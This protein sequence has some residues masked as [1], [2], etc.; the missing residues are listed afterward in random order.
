MYDITKDILSNC[1]L[2]HIRYLFLTFQLI[3]TKEYTQA[4]DRNWHLKHFCCFAC[5]VPLGGQKYV[6]RENKPYC[7][8]C[9]DV[10]FAKTCLHCQ[11]NI[12]A[13]AKRITYKEHHW[14]A[15][16][17][18]FSCHTCKKNMLGQQFIYR[19]EKVYCTPACAKRK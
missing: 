11:Q 2:Y 3:F 15:T 19:R 10:L 8:T 16:E 4:E 14:H 18:C 12:N 6:A 7:M 1:G 13:D 5:D 9:Y 17:N